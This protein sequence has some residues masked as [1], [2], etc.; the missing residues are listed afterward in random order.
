[1]LSNG[2]FESGDATWEKWG[3]PEVT[4]SESR[5]GTHSL[6]VKINSG[7]ASSTVSVESGKKYAV[8]LWVK[9]S[10]AGAVSANIGLNTFG[11]QEGT[12]PIPFTGS[13]S[14]EYQEIVF[15][16]T[17][18]TSSMRIAFWNDS[19]IDYYI[20]DAVIRE[21]VDQEK[22]SIPGE[23][24][25][26]HQPQAL[27]LNWQGSVDNEGVQAYEISYKKFGTDT[28]S[29]ATAAHDQSQ[30]RYSYTLDGLDAYSNYFIKVSAVDTSGNRSDAATAIASTG[31]PNLLSNAGF[32]SGTIGGWEVWTSLETTQ[33]E[34]HGGDY[35]LLV[36]PNTG[37]AS[38]TVAIEPDTSYVIGFWIK[39][40]NGNSQ[41][42][43]V[44][45]SFFGPGG[46]VAV[47][48]PV[49]GTTE[50]QYRELVYQ[51]SANSTHARINLW[52]NSGEN[53]VMDDI[54]IAKLPPVPAELLPSTPG[55][56]VASEVT[57]LSVELQWDPSTDV[58]GVARY[59]VSY[60]EEDE[61]QWTTIAVPADHQQSVYQ[62][63]VNNLLPSTS[64]AFR[65]YAQNETDLLS[66]YASVTASTLQMNPVNPAASQEARGLLNRLYDIT[67]NGILSGQHNYYEAPNEWY[68]K[69]ADLTGYYP[70]LWGSDFAFYTGGDIGALRQ[71]MVNTAIARWNE[72]A[73]VA[74]TFHQSKPSDG[75]TAGWS[76]VQGSYTEAEM[77]E[78]VTP[79]TDL[80]NAWLAQIDEVAQYLKQLRD[81]GV[82]VL[83]RPYHEMNATFF[84]WGGKPELFKQLWVNMYERYTDYHGLDNLI[85]V[86]NPNALNA[87]SF[88]EAPYYPGHS[89]VDVLAADIYNND[90]QQR[91]YDELLAIGEGRAIGI[92][93]NGELPNI[94]TLKLSQSRYAWFMTWPGFLTDNNTLGTIQSLYSNTYTLNNGETGLGPYVPPIPESYVIDDFEGYDG[95]DANL[96]N[97]W[98][99]NTAGNSVT[100]ALDGTKKHDGLYAM[101]LD[102]TIGDPGFSGV[103]RTYSDSWTGAGAIQFWLKPD[104]SKR[105]LTV[106]FHESN[107]EVW[108]AGFTLTGKSARIVK[109]PFTSFAHPGWFQG[110]NGIVEPDT[111][112]E[113]A[114]YFGQG[115]G[116]PGSGTI[117]VDDIEAVKL[118]DDEGNG[119]NGNNDK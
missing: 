14:W 31:G 6:L 4:E 57:G 20:D 86:W 114:F 113:I 116:K 3:V 99:R 106:Q 105:Q 75:P 63:S 87:W 79:G 51:T 37:G 45:V 53:Y 44:S 38:E 18:D 16:A 77:T 32:E 26:T 88:E 98:R 108:E 24:S 95:L 62:Y 119:N 29:A 71:Q 115:E 46:E 8:G 70:G 22:P 101:R 100:A 42:A 7:G 60:K 28:W 21:A 92:G 50:W 2:G 103:Y 74:L 17:D 104:A 15:T 19:G 118:S 111:I 5:S 93:E 25:V 85:W 112:K 84:W 10:A 80:Y 59:L 33:T 96:A 47:P 13:T 27:I 83:W 110:G 40:A 97:K 52:N 76:S 64:Y 36:L 34:H 54:Q 109:I 49:Q 81:A 94:D 66:D 58:L 67:G 65:I 107:G 1:M 89:Y 9:F 12:I 55:N 48:I 78:L 61:Q 68:Q 72:G 43:N 82:P 91:H 56:S 102:Y 73:V 23:L 39:S 117:Y 30:I 11:S 69:A 90:Y 41:D 35:S